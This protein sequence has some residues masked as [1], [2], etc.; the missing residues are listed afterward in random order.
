MKTEIMLV[1]PC[2]GK[3]KLM[4]VELLNCYV[5]RSRCFLFETICS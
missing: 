2:Y 1:I 5:Y 3:N 4:H